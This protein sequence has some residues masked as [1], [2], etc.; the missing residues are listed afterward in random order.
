MSKIEKP[1]KMEVKD[2][3][4]GTFFGQAIGD[5]LGLATEFMTKAEAQEK[6]PDGLKEY[7][8]IVRDYHRAKFRPGS[9]SN[10]TGMMLCIANAIIENK[11]INLHTIARNF[12]QW[13]YAPET[14]GM[15]QTTF[16]VASVAEYVEK[17]QPSG[18]ADLANVAH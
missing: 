3:I 18:R 13:L 17:A 1:Q 15:G 5:A 9:W 10:D 8:Q 6:Y 11:G 16:K 2:K 14:R 4:Y 7:S 12:K